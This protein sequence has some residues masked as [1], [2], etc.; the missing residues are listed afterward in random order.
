M[1]NATLD[2]AR[3][4]VLLRFPGAFAKYVG[5]SLRFVIVAEPGGREISPHRARQRDAWAS[6]ARRI[7]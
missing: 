4:K 2:T 1:S 6:A 5:L 7:R 3:Q